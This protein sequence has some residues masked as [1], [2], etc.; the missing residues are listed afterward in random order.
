MKTLHQNNPPKV[1]LVVIFLVFLIAIFLGNFLRKPFFPIF[2]SILKYG[3]QAIEQIKPD[4][5]KENSRLIEENESLKTRII[6]LEYLEKENQELKSFFSRLPGEKTAKEYILAS[7][8]SKPPQSPYDV[9]IIDVGQDNGIKNGM[10]VFAYGDI[11]L[12][13]IVEVASKESKI[14]LFSFP[15]EKINVLIQNSTG[16]ENISVTAEGLGGGNFK[17]KLPDSIEVKIGDKITGTGL[18]AQ[19]GGLLILG[20]V[21]KI[22]T[23]QSDPFQKIYFRT[24]INIRYLSRVLIER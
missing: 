17:I 6:S 1:K 21:E 10:R 5:K 9:L 7:I 16:G 8:I 24:P 13:Y 4:T 2:G 15:G 23:N 18:P 19:A 12:G 14:K 3:W 20:V 22:E 11:L